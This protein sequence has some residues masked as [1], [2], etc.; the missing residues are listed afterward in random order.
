MVKLEPKFMFLWFVFFMPLL[1]SHAN[2]V[3][4]V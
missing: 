3:L 1:Q 4:L 2:V